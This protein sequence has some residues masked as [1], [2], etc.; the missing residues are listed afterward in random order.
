MA[1]LVKEVRLIKAENGTDPKTGKLINS[2]KYWNG[3]LYDDESWTAEWGRVG[4]E[5]PESGTW[6]GAR[7]FES[8][9]KE[10]LGP[11]K[12]YTEQK[13]IGEA[14]ASV[15]PASVVKNSDLHTIARAQLLKSSSPVLDRL[16]KRFVD[17]NVHNTTLRT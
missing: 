15:S 12:G 13:T 16:I 8:K 10:K 14:T 11:K 5:N 6:N 7:K 9:V 3:K 17:A 4:C 1:T 2:Y